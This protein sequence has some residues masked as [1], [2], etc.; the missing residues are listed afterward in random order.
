M[1]SVDLSRRCEKMDSIRKAKEK[2]DKCQTL[3]SLGFTLERGGDLKDLETH[4]NENNDCE[5]KI[6]QQ[7]GFKRSIGSKENLSVR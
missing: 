1:R 3:S 2:E 7:V 4:Q 6:F 5:K